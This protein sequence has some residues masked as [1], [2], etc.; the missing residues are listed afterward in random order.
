MIAA[1]VI[2]QNKDF[3][4]Y[5]KIC[6]RL[7]KWSLQ[8]DEGGK[9]RKDPEMGNDIARAL[10]KAT[11]KPSEDNINHAKALYYLGKSL[12]EYELF[13]NAEE[14]E[15]KCLDI[16]KKLNGQEVN[17]FKVKAMIILGRCKYNQGVFDKSEKIL[18]EAKAISKTERYYKPCDASD[19]NQSLSL[20]QLQLNKFK[21]ALSNADA[22]LSGGVAMNPGILTNRGKC[23]M[24]LEDFNKAVLDFESAKRLLGEKPNKMKEASLK[25]YLGFCYLALG[26]IKEATVEINNAQQDTEAVLEE[27][28][29]DPDIIEIHILA[30][31]NATRT[32]Q[33]EKALDFL[34]TGLS[35]A[36]NIFVSTPDHPQI[37]DC[38][39]HIG[40]LMIDRKKD[41]D[42]Q[43]H[44]ENA[45]SMQKEVYKESNSKHLAIVKCYRGLAH[46]FLIQKNQ[47]KACANIQSGLSMVEE[48]LPESMLHAQLLLVQGEIEL[49]LRQD[50]DKAEKAFNGALKIFEEKYVEHKLPARAMILINMAK[51]LAKK[52]EYDKAMESIEKSLKLL[53]D[54][55]EDGK[56]PNK[57]LALKVKAVIEEKQGNTE[58]AVKSLE[59]SKKAL[60]DYQR[61]SGSVFLVTGDTIDQQIDDLKNLLNEEKL[62]EKQGKVDEKKKSIRKRVTI[63]EDIAIQEDSLLTAA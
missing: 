18:L 3:S 50:F 60:V 24:V 49:K 27:E 31:Q 53:D 7:I 4:S 41:T 34:E 32:G 29:E 62:F 25:A 39:M 59:E 21:E 10:L 33:Y 57:V 56:G 14:K 8:I 19:V 12:Y 11:S 30:G 47:E 5:V 26:K 46:L 43:E 28:E 61:N 38:L 55:Y 45:L 51:V 58:D 20:T 15:N 2:E 35:L 16:L 36:E 40:L 1:R 13:E 48:L 44:L 9:R 37:A 52:E 22:A 54:I 17:Q 42:A 6:E 63:L 23:Y